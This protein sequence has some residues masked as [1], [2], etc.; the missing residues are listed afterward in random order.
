AAA[1]VALMALGRRRASLVEVLLIVIFV[2]QA[3]V[4]VRQVPVCAL[5][6]APIFAVRLCERFRLARELAPPRLPNAVIAVNWLL[7]VVLLVAGLLLLN[8]PNVSRALQLRREPGVADMPL[9]GARFIEDRNLP[10]PVFNCQPWGGYLIYRW[11]PGRRVFI[12]G[13]I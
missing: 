5:V 13:R 7:L 3:L 11:Y 12:D 10:D 6:L 1:V 4:S 8:R 2:G 9:E